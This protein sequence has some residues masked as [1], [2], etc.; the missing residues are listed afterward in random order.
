MPETI[1]AATRVGSASPLPDR[2][3]KPWADSR[4]NKVAPTATRALV[5]SPAIR[6]RNW[7]SNPMTAPRPTPVPTRSS[8][9]KVVMIR[10][11]SGVRALPDRRRPDVSPA[12]NLR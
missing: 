9:S 3:P 2:P 6:A 11:F 12:G 10:L 4:T 1:C 7:R 5:R 8:I